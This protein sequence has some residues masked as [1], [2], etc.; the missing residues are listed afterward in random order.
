MNNTIPADWA[1][2]SELNSLCTK[3]SAGIEK[4]WTIQGFTHGRAPKVDV[5]SVGAR[6]I[7]LGSFE[8]RNG[9]YDCNSVYCFID[10][11]NGDV[12]KGSWKAPVKNG[13]RGNLRDADILSKCGVYGLQYLKGDNQRL[14]TNYITIAHLLK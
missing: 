12:L 13:V 4:Y 11:N 8:D 5:T 14:S 1:F 10:K 3:I 7:K 2:H 6:Y 9:K